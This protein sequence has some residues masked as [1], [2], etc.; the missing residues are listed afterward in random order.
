MQQHV[1]VLTLGVAEVSRAH[2]FYIDGL[3]WRPTLYVPGEV[4]FFQV[5][6]GVVLALWSV[7]AMAAEAGAT[8]PPVTE[9]GRAAITLGHNVAGEAEV[10]DVLAAARDAGGVVLVPG[11]RRAWGGY[12]GYFADPDGYRWEVAHNPGLV[13]RPDGRVVIG[14][15]SDEP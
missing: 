4:L 12:S 15:A 14:S 1:N 9:Q 7:E 13:V 5:G 3:G 11:A 10:D 2:A 8:V 6:G